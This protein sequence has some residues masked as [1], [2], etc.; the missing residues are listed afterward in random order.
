M[1]RPGTQVT[2]HYPRTC[3][4]ATPYE[5]RTGTVRSVVDGGFRPGANVLVD[6]REVY[7]SFIHLR[8]ML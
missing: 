6:G 3:R 8:E 5:G 2:I 1:I 4:V 7:V